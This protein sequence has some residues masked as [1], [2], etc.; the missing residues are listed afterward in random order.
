MAILRLDRVER[1]VF[2]NEAAL[3]LFGDDVSG[4]PISSVLRHPDF[5]QALGE[6]IGTGQK[7]TVP[8]TMTA[9]SGVAYLL[10]HIL[11]A[12]PGDTAELFVAFDDQTALRQAAAIRRDFVANVSHELRTPLTALVGFIETLKGAARDDPA[13]RDRFLNIMESEASRM[14]RLVNDLLSLSRVEADEH[15]RPSEIV[16]ILALLRAVIATHRDQ[17][18]AAGVAIDIK[19]TEETINVRGDP[20]QLMQVF[21]NLTENGIKYGGSGGVLHFSICRVAR[22]PK[23]R[24]PA[25]IIEVSDDGEGIDPIHLPRLTERFYRVD[26]HRSREKGGTGLGLAIVKHIVNRHRGRF[27][28]ESEPGKG[29]N[30]IVILPDF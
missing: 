25:V 11:P 30:F 20:D 3:A 23:L 28:I 13:T 21:H 9:K 7:A 16:D 22:E 29:S 12:E 4:R 14:I 8:L 1:V 24:G 5:H 17:A 26:N 6:V 18:R 27:K 19:S 10:A 2:A 15:R